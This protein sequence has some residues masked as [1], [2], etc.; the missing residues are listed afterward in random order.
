MLV[1]C[2]PLPVV[3]RVVRRTLQAVAQVHRWAALCFEEGGRGRAPPCRVPH[4][5]NKSV[6]HAL[7]PCAPW[8]AAM[9]WCTAP[10]TPST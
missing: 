5:N 10:S 8:F 6:R 2:L 3:K 9:G 7:R 1:G 4:L